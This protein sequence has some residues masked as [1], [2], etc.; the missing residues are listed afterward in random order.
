MNRVELVSTSAHLATVVQRALTAPRVAVDIESNGFFRYHERVCL[1]QLMVFDAAYIVDPLAIQDVGPL[2]ELLSSAAVEKIFHAGDYD[3]RS[4][5]RDWGFRVRN[6]FDTGISAAL[7]GSTGVGLQTVLQEHL[8][9]ELAKE[10]RLQRS[11][12]TNRPLSSEAIE[13]AANDVLHL[14]K[15]RD[16]LAKRLE[17]LSR[18]DW[19]T[20]EFAF[21][22][23]VRH[24]ESDPTL[25]YLAVKG[26]RDLDGRGLAIL[27]SLYRFRESIAE[28]IDRSPFRVMANTAL[29]E[30]SVD[31]KAD[32]AKVKGLGRY[33]RRPANSQLKRAIQEGIKSPPL[34]LPRPDSDQPRLSREERDALRDRL[35]SLRSWR[36]EIAQDLQLDSGLIWPI[37]SL[38]RLARHP[39]SL[40]AELEDP[41]IRAWQ[42]R[43][44]GDALEKAVSGLNGAA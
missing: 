32:L 13:Y 4:F 42:K 3:L 11:D 14:A 30:L 18:L 17:E 1:V 29:I 26:S 20:E 12:W 39:E 15:L 7:I 16:V 31:P 28:R 44:F 27:R 25:D 6:L 40:S 9:V 37:A 35:R 34:R 24:T 5:D 2:G 33:G 10:R 41:Q 38:R 36:G 43:E 23:G 19:A 8:N 22:E 21:L